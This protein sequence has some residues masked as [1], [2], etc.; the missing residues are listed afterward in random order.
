M[1]AAYKIRENLN[2][3][4]AEILGCKEDDVEIL[5]A[6]AYSKN[7]PSNT[8]DF[9][10]LALQ[11]Y[12]IGLNPSCFGYFR[13]PKMV[14][15]HENGQGEAYSNFTFGA[16]I[17]EIEVDIETG[18]IQV[19]KVTPVYD[20]GKAINPLLLKGQIEGAALQGMGYALMEEIVYDGAVIM[21]PT[22][23]DYHIPTS[24]DIPEIDPTLVEH[25]FRYGPF[26]AK[27]MG[28]A[29]L[30]PMAS[31]IANAIYNA[32]GVRIKEL[33]ATPERVLAAIQEGR[34]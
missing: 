1:V 3:V 12:N 31:A 23:Q 26:G 25:R 16:H 32:V 11:C 4:A 30:I 2:K 10:E 19:L 22:F 33:P 6:K 15:D 8:L 29:P 5:D 14:F 20:V 27:G 21:N 17:V 34:G 13:A 18:Q 24:M 28:E 9:Q 7:N